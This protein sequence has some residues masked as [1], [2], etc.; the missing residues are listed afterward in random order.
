[1]VHMTHVFVREVDSPQQSIIIPSMY[2]KMGVIEHKLGETYCYALDNYDNEPPK[3][4]DIVDANN[5]II[6]SGRIIVPEDEAENLYLDPHLTLQQKNNIIRSDYVIVRERQEQMDWVPDKDC[7][8]KEDPVSME[9][10]PEGRGFRLEAENGYCYDVKS[11]SSIKQTN[12]SPTG[13]RTR[14][15][16]TSNDINRINAYERISR[17]GKKKSKKT[18]KKRKS[19]N[20]KRKDNKNKKTVKKR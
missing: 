11:L 10:I 7:V 12:R 13:P 18:N 4:I 16:F 1:M 17:G 14:N 6:Y 3:Y 15:P 5:N 8:G 20:K 2:N 19:I 9:L